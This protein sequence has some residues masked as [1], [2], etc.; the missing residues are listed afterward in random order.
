[1]E[2]KKPKKTRSHGE[3]SKSSRN[4]H[5]PLSSPIAG[6]RPP[7][8]DRVKS[9]PL[10]AQSTKTQHDGRAR[11]APVKPAAREKEDVHNPSSH[12]VE[13]RG[14]KTQSTSIPIPVRVCSC[15]GHLKLLFVLT[16]PY[17]T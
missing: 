9:A 2:S 5:Q 12:T 15:T 7:L 17:T 1:M 11:H 6:S 4:S 14:L 8:K 13:Q 3:A 16:G 10:I